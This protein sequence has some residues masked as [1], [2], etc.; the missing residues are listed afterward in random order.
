MTCKS[1]LHVTRPSLLLKLFYFRYVEYFIRFINWFEFLSLFVDS[2]CLLLCTLYLIISVRFCNNFF[3][4]IQSIL[5]SIENVH[6]FLLHFLFSIYS[7]F[8]QFR[9]STDKELS[10][11][12]RALPQFLAVSCKNLVLLG[13]LLV[14]FRLII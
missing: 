9:H 7:I 4:S 14:L 11:C 10:V 6:T 1:L 3:S 2:I 8:I 12:R 5:I 13:K